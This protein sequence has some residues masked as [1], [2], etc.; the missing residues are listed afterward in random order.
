MTVTPFV[1]DDPADRSVARDASFKLTLDDWA[2]G[3]TGAE[4]VDYGISGA[5]GGLLPSW[6]G[7][8]SSSLSLYGRAPEAGFEP[9][10]IT[11]TITDAH[12]ATSTTTFTLYVCMY[13]Y[14]I[15]IYCNII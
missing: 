5:D 10:D 9:I 6:L 13:V 15:L 1:L 14:N 2:A 7:F 4:I 8:D 3:Q 11:L 12:G